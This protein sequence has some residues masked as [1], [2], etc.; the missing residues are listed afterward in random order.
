MGCPV[1]IGPEIILKYFTA[2]ETDQTRRLVVIGDLGVLKSCAVELNIPAVLTPWH[3][4]DRP[5]A[6]TIP[7]LEATHL[8]P[9]ELRWGQPTA[10]TGQAMATYIKRAAQDIDK[11][12]FSCLVTCPISKS[13]LHDAGYNYPGHTEMLA[14]LSHSSEPIM[15]MAGT[16]LRVTLAT[17]HCALAEVPAL[18]SSKR[19]IRLI[20]ITHTSLVRDFG[21]AHPQIAVAGLNPHAGEDGIFG[22]EEEEIIFP[23]VHAAQTAGITVSGPFPPDTVFHKAASG[24]FDAVVCMYH[25]QGLIPFKLLHFSD[26]VNVSLGLPFIRTSV[27]H[28]T[29]Y[30]IAGQGKATASSLHAAVEMAVQMYHNRR[31]YQANA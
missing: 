18:L 2:A 9:E 19:I 4:G 12:I 15:M 25:D 10:T 8:N 1:G 16:T 11:G 23:A 26:G 6:G 20:E 22:H 3:P 21:I 30:D 7:V 31:N 5:V 17:I 14:D 28:G 27:D 29:A 13:A 24:L